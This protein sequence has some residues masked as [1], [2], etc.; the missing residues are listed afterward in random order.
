MKVMARPTPLA[1]DFHIKRYSNYSAL[2]NSYSLVVIAIFI[3]HA[4]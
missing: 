3:H 2:L 4:E 1:G